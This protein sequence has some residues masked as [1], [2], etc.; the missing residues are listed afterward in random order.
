MHQ[1]CPE[2]LYQIHPKVPSIQMVPFHNKMHI[3]CFYKAKEEISERPSL[4][5][6]LSQ[7]SPVRTHEPGQDHARAVHS[8]S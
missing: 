4:H 3:T 5:H 8:P 6:L 2:C 1:L 7:D